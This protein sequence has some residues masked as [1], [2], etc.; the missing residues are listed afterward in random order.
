M[1][2]LVHTPKDREEMLKKLSLSSL[3]KLFS[4][5]PAK[6]RNPKIDLP[7]PMGEPE[8]ERL[9]AELARGN[10][11][12]AKSCFLGAGCYD[13][14]LPAAVTELVGRGEF[15]TAYTPYQAEM[16]QGILQAIYEYQTMVCRLTGMDA[17][18][19][20]LYDAG[21][22]CWEGVVMAMAAKKRRAV[23]VSPGLNP[24]YRQVIGS[25]AAATGTEV[26]VPCLRH[27]GDDNASLKQ[28]LGKGPAAYL[29]QYPDFFGRLPDLEKAAEAAHAAGGCLVVATNMISLGLL[30]P[31]GELGADIVVAEGQLLGNS[32]NYGGPLLGVMAAK[33]EFLRRMPGRI[34]GATVDS[35]GRRGFVLTLQAREQHIKRERAGS[36]ICTNQALCMLAF[37]IHL[38]LL[39]ASGLRKL[40]LLNLSKAEY[41]R[42]R[43]AGLRG[44]SLPLEGPCFNEFVVKSE[45]PVAEVMAKLAHKGILGG[46]P[47]GEYYPEMKDC[48]LVCVTEKRTKGEM[49]RYIEGLNG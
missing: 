33:Q 13:H 36:N 18:N 3:D 28:M 24:H 9:A 30:K 48:F 34:A 29:L 35:K 45:A 27:G 49:D 8:L 41:L 12:A 47:L 15:Y 22:A 40:A 25:S 21:T 38:S 39:G 17:A 31:P 23:V 43:I 32:M 20:S 42:Q 19:A 7:R 16:S 5:I 1:E 6:L 37:S 2:Y 14:Y 44:F 46:L 11:A 10:P 26:L 4:D